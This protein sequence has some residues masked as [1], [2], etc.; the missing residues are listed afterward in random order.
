MET[1]RSRLPRS[2]Q[3]LPVPLYVFLLHSLFLKLQVP[4]QP[5]PEDDRLSHLCALNA[6]RSHSPLPAVSPAQ[7][8]P[9]WP[10]P[11]QA[12]P[13][14]P[15]RPQSRHPRPSLRAVSAAQP[16]RSRPV[17]WPAAPLPHF[18][19]LC[20]R[21]WFFL[22]AAAPLLPVPLRPVP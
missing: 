11:G 21:P 8:V 19:P 16:A 12:A 22:R 7:S 9:P 2:A 10:V 14:P 20:S 4:A 6:P 17:H 5:V 1:E 3:P 15:A 13:L 18:P